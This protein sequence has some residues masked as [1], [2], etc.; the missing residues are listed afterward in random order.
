EWRYEVAM[1]KGAEE[2]AIQ[3]TFAGS[4]HAELEVHDGAQDFV[5]EV[6]IENGAKWSQLEPHNGSWLL[7]DDDSLHRIRY[8]FLLKDGCDKL[9]N[10]DVAVHY[11][12]AFVASPSVW[13][14]HP[15]TADDG[16][17]YRIHVSGPGE[18]RCVCGVFPARS[19]EPGVYSGDASDLQRAPPS[20]FG[21][22]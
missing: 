21:P 19:G 9:R 8:R 11:D 20:A 13:L 15:S 6:E 7:P 10:P 14:L 22:M 2:L 1:E 16:G 4:R 18:V 17:T 5:R 12:T 3:A